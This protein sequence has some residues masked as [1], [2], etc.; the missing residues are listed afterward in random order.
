[1]MMSQHP[2]EYSFGHHWS[3]ATQGL[4]EYLSMFDGY[5]NKYPNTRNLHITVVY[6]AKG[7]DVKRLTS[8]PFAVLSATRSSHTPSGFALKYLNNSRKHAGRPSTK[9]LSDVFSSIRQFKEYAAAPSRAVIIQYRLPKDSHPFC[10]PSLFTI[11]T[12]TW[13]VH[14]NY[15]D[16]GS[17]HECM[18]S[19]Y[20]RY[21]EITK[22]RSFSWDE[23][24]MLA[25]ARCDA[26]DDILN[27]P[28]DMLRHAFAQLHPGKVEHTVFQQ[29]CA[30]STAVQRV[31]I[32][33][34]YVFSPQV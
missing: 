34:A 2:G 32:F 4:Q 23:L 16:L 18:G 20:V 13:F 31:T 9:T 30:E 5:W 7:S 21:L 12:Y 1:M 25:G 6:A 8:H 3:T 14:K 24:R 22:G 28:A 26:A 15:T 19:M 29:V 33:P 27:M 11:E 17:T 10:W